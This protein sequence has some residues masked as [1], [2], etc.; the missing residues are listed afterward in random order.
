MRAPKRHSHY[1]SGGFHFL[2][3]PVS[4][5]AMTIQAQTAQAP[6][7]QL[8]G[9]AALTG[10][11]MALAADCN[12]P[13]A[14]LEHAFDS[15]LRDKGTA[16]SEVTR[17]KGMMMQSRMAFRGAARSYGCDEVKRTIDDLLGNRH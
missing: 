12:L 3:V 11:Y 6:A 9:F 8:E 7:N 2:V 14:P 4:V 15:I 13:T 10:G 16:P 17:L 1:C 5:I